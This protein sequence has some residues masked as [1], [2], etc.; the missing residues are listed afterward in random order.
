[1]LA[2]SYQ[3]HFDRPI[4]SHIAHQRMR[5][6]ECQNECQ[7]LSLQ[8][9]VMLRLLEPNVPMS[10][11]LSISHFELGICRHKHELRVLYTVQYPFGTAPPS[12]Y[13]I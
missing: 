5:Q 9:F 12:G 3:K 1:M 7:T 11:I 8:W 6:R 10:A 4:G 13:E 2:K